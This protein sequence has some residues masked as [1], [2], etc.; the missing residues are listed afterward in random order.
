MTNFLFE[1]HD[2]TEKQCFKCQQVKPLEDFYKHPEMADGHLN[3]C[4]VCTK[5]DVNSNRA[6]KINYYQMYDRQRFQIDPNRRAYQLE[7]MRTWSQR[8]SEKSTEIKRDWNGRNPHKTLAKQVINNAVR[9]GK[10]IKP[11]ACQICEATEDLHGHH[12]DYTKPLDVWWL[13]PSC[14]HL[15]HRLE[16]NAMRNHETQSLAA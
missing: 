13:C 6:D 5:I 14:H 7:Q 10:I 16:R 11:N 2:M 4:K 9:N 1:V 3:K 15:L 12:H 8:N